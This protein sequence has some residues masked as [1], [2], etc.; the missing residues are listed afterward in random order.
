MIKKELFAHH[1]AHVGRKKEGTEKRIKSILSKNDI[2]IRV[3]PSIEVKNLTRVM[4]V[5]RLIQYLKEWRNTGKET[6]TGLITWRNTS[7]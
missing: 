2:R 4:R 5:L 1:N 3:A 6:A 7:T